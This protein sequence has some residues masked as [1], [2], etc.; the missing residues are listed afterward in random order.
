MRTA[1]RQVMGDFAELDR[2][3]VTKRLRDGRLAK[4]AVG[5]KA[6]GDYP[7]GSAATGKGRDCDAGPVEAEQ[8]AVIRIVELAAPTV[9]S[10]SRWTQRGISPAGQPL[11]RLQPYAT[12][13]SG[14]SPTESWESGRP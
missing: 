13:P 11:G 1:I 9:T 4:A 7:F 12:S 2:K 14:R 5:R 8:R 6:V 10:P 3:M